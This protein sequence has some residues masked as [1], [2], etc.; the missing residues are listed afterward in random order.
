MKQTTTLLLQGII[1]FLVI[2]GL[3]YIVE[4]RMDWIFAVGTTAGFLI[5][6]FLVR[7]R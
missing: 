7:R 3:S 2:G 6:S 4:G 1:V 5:V